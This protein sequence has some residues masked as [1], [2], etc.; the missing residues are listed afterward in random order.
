MRH[1]FDSKLFIKMSKM[2]LKIRKSLQKQMSIQESEL[3]LVKINLLYIYIYSAS[4]KSNHMNLT[5]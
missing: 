4:L 2:Q 5:L 3:Q 1:R